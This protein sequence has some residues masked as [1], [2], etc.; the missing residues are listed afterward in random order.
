MDAD[1]TRTRSGNRRKP[2]CPNCG[3]VLRVTPRKRWVE[4]QT[5]QCVEC[6]KSRP[7]ES[8]WSNPML[9]MALAEKEDADGR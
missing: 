7:D 5:W 6:A 8:E 1:A 9:E 3:H 2:N 4:Q